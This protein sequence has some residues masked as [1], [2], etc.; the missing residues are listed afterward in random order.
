MIEKII[1]SCDKIT[2]N[3]KRTVPENISRVEHYTNIIE[4]A[5]QTAHSI[6]H[7]NTKTSTP[8]YVVCSADFVPIFCFSRNFLLLP[9]AEINGT[10]VNGVHR[11]PR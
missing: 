4:R 3:I 6:V 9:V 5:H 11:R 7:N 8:N 2:L 1:K 10:Y